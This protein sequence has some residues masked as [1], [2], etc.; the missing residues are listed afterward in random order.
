VYYLAS[1]VGALLGLDALTFAIVFVMAAIGARIL[2]AAIDSTLLAVSFFPI[3]ALAAALANF[4]AQE[5]GMSA[6]FDVPFE[7]ITLIQM[8]T[9]DEVMTVVT[10]TFAGMLVGLGGILAI[11]RVW[12]HTP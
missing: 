4:V 1:I 10:V 11:Y 5:S 9:V 7:Q 8:V 6:A 3:L 2:R 12:G